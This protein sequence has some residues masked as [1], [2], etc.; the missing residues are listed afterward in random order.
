MSEKALRFGCF[1]VLAEIERGVGERGEVYKAICVKDDFGMVALGTVVALKVVEVVDDDHGARLHARAL[2]LMRLAQPEV[3][4]CFGYFVEGE[5]QF[6]KRGVFIFEWL[7]GESLK[8]RLR[9]ELGGLDA[10]EFLRLGEK[11]LSAL[12]DLSSGGVAHLDIKPGNIFL[13]RNGEVKLIDFRR[14]QP[15]D[16]PTVPP[17]ILKNDS[18]DYAA[19]EFYYASSDYQGDHF[20][21]DERSD[22]FSLGVCLHEMIAGA[23]P[24][25]SE[26]RLMLNDDKSFSYFSRWGKARDG[27]IGDPIMIRPIVNRLLIGAVDVLTKALRS[28]RAE[29]YAAFADFAVSFK[30]I[31]SRE[32]THGDYTWRMLRFVGRGGFGEVFKA[33]DVKTGQDVAIKCLLKSQYVDRFRREARVLSSLNDSSL[34][35]FITFF[36]KEIGGCE[37]AFLV[38][39]YLEGMPGKSLRDELRRAS[40]K[41]IRRGLIIRAFVKYAHGLAVLHAKKIVHLNI[42]PS[43]LYFPADGID[44]AVIMSSTIVRDMSCSLTAGAV[45]GTLD[46]MPPEV[47]D[48]GDLGSPAM[49]IFALG[50]SLYEALSNKMAYPRLPTGTNGLLAFVKRS[51]DKTRPNIDE[52]SYADL[53]DLVCLVREMTEPDVTKR[54]KEAAEVE[55]RLRALLSDRKDGDAVADG[56]SESNAFCTAMPSDGYGPEGSSAKA[57]DPDEKMRRSKDALLR[58]RC[59]AKNVTEEMIVDREVQKQFRELTQLQ[60]ESI[61]SAVRVL[62]NGNQI[63]KK[64]LSGN[65]PDLD[66]GHLMDMNV[67]TDEKLTDF[68]MAAARWLNLPYE[69]VSARYDSQLHGSTQVSIN[70]RENTLMVSLDAERRS[71]SLAVKAFIACAVSDT[72]QIATRIVGVG[73]DSVPVDEIC[74]ACSGFVGILLNATQLLR[75]ADDGVRLKQYSRLPVVRIAWT[76][77]MAQLINR[78]LN[79]ECQVFCPPC[80]L[81]DFAQ[82]VFERVSARVRE[83]F[84]WAKDLIPELRELV[85][86]FLGGDMHGRR[87]SLSMQ[88]PVLAGRSRACEIYIPKTPTMILSREHFRLTRENGWTYAE[89]MG[90]RNG[91][92]VNDT[93][94]FSGER[95]RIMEGDVVTLRGIS[96]VKFVIVSGAGEYGKP[97]DDATV[98]RMLRET[99]EEQARPQVFQQADEDSPTAKTGHV[100]NFGETVGNVLYPE[101]DGETFSDENAEDSRL[102]D[103]SVIE[104]EFKRMQM[105]QAARR[106]RRLRCCFIAA[107]LCL[108]LLSLYGLVKWLAVH[109]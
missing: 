1:R 79:D 15:R 47:V 99:S 12:V 94:L 31:R 83:D 43:K 81:S 74:A 52:S 100:D 46:Y 11:L 84:T 92:F 91:S 25:Q 80:G 86:V 10:D 40:G 5:H 16:E 89:D 19:S 44:R 29:R 98:D 4:R 87:L 7:E 53:P 109:T 28:N 32:L 56:G 51:K 73:R 82:G 42:K 34:V 58:K 70:H 61:I 48:A 105:A 93:R 17:Y 88:K 18:F 36:E 37:H 71:D 77:C 30:A 62:L 66:I 57:F 101:S 38:M 96:D 108:C 75:T 26:E 106:R 2:E 13:C 22:V 76:Y 103:F 45:L 78:K 63:V 27:K 33:R 69:H 64:V 50:L 95:K 102:P 9:R 60:K 107:A 24:Y 65:A 41:V 14:P 54:L 104:Q 72:R 85:V 59:R 21:G 68:T 90:S 20:I 6:C 39:E 3:E 8:D 23:L 49:D 67:S 97:L 35:H 55:R